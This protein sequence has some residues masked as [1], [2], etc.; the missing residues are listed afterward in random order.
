MTMSSETV[1]IKWNGKEYDAT[2]L[3]GGDLYAIANIRDDGLDEVVSA[4]ELEMIDNHK[5]VAVAK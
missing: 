2:P 4:R 1:K 5:N 3:Y